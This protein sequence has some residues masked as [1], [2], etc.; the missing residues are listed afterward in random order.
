MTF[1][2]FRRLIRIDSSCF[3]T[4]FLRNFSSFNVNVDYK[5]SELPTNMSG[6]EI[7]GYNGLQSLKLTTRLDVP[8]ITR[9]N[10]VLVETK[11][12]SVNP[13]DAMMTGM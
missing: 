3:K 12:A 6:W 11:A 2:T 1:L 9:P 5:P 8:P 10:E 4:S 13:L 7:C